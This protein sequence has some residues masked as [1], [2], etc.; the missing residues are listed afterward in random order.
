MI[1]STLVNISMFRVRFA[2]CVDCVRVKE[3]NSAIGRRITIAD[4]TIDFGSNTG[5][6]SVVNIS[7]GNLAQNIIKLSDARIE[8]TGSLD[9]E[10]GL[11]RIQDSSTQ[12]LAFPTSSVE[13]DN[14]AVQFSGDAQSSTTNAVYLKTARA[15]GT[16][17]NVLIKNCYLNSMNNI[18]AGNWYSNVSAYTIPSNGIINLFAFG[19]GQSGGSN[20]DVIAFNFIKLFGFIKMD[21]PILKASRGSA[22]GRAWFF[23]TISDPAAGKAPLII[24]NG[25]DWLYMDGTVVT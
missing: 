23:R 13:L 19:T 3:S 6:R 16:D 18:L 15:G 22:S 5:F 10:N 25:T 11:V 9:S 1:T 8:G 12:T 14:I 24:S 21:E 7:S 4:F 17:T 2:G 20:G